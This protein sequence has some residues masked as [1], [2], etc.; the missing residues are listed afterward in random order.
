[1]KNDIYLTGFSGQIG[2][3]LRNVFSK[4]NIKITLLGRKEPLL[5]Q[6]ELFI[7]FDLNKKFNPDSIVNKIILIHLAHDF[8]KYKSNVNFSGTKNLLSFFSNQSSTRF[9]FISTPHGD[10]PKM[11]SIYQSEKKVTENLFSK[12]DLILMPSFIHSKKGRTN[13]LFKLIEKLRVPILIPKQV[14]DIAPIELSTFCEFLA[15]EENLLNLKGRY[16]LL[17]KRNLSFP[18]FLKDLYNLNS[19]KVPNFFF[20]LLIKILSLIPSHRIFYIEERIKGLMNLPNLKKTKEK[21]ISIS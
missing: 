14:N 5:N 2:T 19:L 8:K 6:N 18:S 10:N 11:D 16:L 4:K 17:G 20:L 12:N 1:M 21:K 3:E 13:S 9:I 15:K 7:F